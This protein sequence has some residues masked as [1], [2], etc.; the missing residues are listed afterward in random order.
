MTKKALCIL[1][2][3]LM[4][5]G[6][7][8]PAMAA[9]SDGQYYIPMENPLAR[10]TT[11]TSSFNFSTT[12]VGASRNFTGGSHMHYSATTHV[13]RVSELHHLGYN[14]TPERRDASGR[15]VRLATVNLPRTGL[16]SNTWLRVGEGHYRFSFNKSLADN[17]PT[18]T[19]ISSNNVRMVLNNV[20]T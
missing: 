4:L 2:A 11:F 13:S 12:L 9:E 14:V 1:L 17:H 16:N 15:Y 7:V 18:H 6:M 19:F 8:M 5:I 20:A 3:A 10:S